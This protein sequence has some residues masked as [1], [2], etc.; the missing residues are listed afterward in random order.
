MFSDGLA[1]VKRRTETQMAIIEDLAKTVK[2]QMNSKNFEDGGVLQKS[3]DSANNKQTA[4]LNKQLH[5]L[6]PKRQISK[7][8]PTLFLALVFLTLYHVGKNEC[9]FI[10]TNFF[11]RNL[12]FFMSFI[13]A[14]FGVFFLKNITWA[15]IDIKQELAASNNQGKEKTEAL[16]PI[17]EEDK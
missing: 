5:L 8:F 17:I 13:C 4:K 3:I 14:A 16:S 2:E 10:N 7:I 1:H 12:F 11:M 15:V 9:W 6:S